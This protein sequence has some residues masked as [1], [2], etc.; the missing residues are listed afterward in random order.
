MSRSLVRRDLWKEHKTGDLRESPP[1][2]IE[3]TT[4]KDVLL[5]WKLPNVLYGLETIE[6]NEFDDYV[7][8][9]EFS[10]V[11][12]SAEIFLPSHTFTNSYSQDETEIDMCSCAKRTYFDSEWKTYLKISFAFQENSFGHLKIRKI[13][14]WSQNN[15]NKFVARYL[16]IK[17]LDKKF[18]IWNL[19]T[20]KTDRTQKNGLICLK[21]HCLTNP[22]SCWLQT[23]WLRY[24]IGK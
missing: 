5:P 3:K 22:T 9:H 6:M 20:K 7:D 2:C 17:D 4:G 8:F 19:V 11:S 18:F 21:N 13:I 1:H 14:F 10:S 12:L 23:A 16:I 15:K 24:C